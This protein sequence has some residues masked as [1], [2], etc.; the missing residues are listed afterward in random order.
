MEG[1]L[2]AVSYPIT[3]STRTGR[4]VYFKIRCDL[5]NT[6]NIKILRSDKLPGNSEVTRRL[7]QCNECLDITTRKPHTFIATVI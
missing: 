6:L 7:Y 4:R 5:C 3:T 1:E 2:K